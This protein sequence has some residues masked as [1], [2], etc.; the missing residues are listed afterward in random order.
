VRSCANSRSHCELNSFGQS[1][2]HQRF[3]REASEAGLVEFRDKKKPPFRARQCREGQGA[4]YPGGVCVGGP[5]LVN[6]AP[7][8]GE[9]QIKG[10]LFLR[11]VASAFRSSRE[12]PDQPMTRALLSSLA[13]LSALLTVTTCLGAPVAP[14]APTAEVA[15]R[16]IHFS[17]IVY[18]FKRPGTTPMSGD[19]QAYFKDCMA[20][21]GEVPTPTP[22]P[23]AQ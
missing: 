23:K 15:K 20:K 9:L 17:Y 14:A 2:F 12:Y 18:P 4:R 16:C 5:P 6:L 22:P 19:R 7:S 3:F 13:R 10:L 8:R 1:D 11:D 21:N